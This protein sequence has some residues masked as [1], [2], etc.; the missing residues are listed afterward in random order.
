MLSRLIT[1]VIFFLT[2]YRFSLFGS[3]YSNK[4]PQTMFV[5]KPFFLKKVVCT[6]A[7]VLPKLVQN[8]AVRA[9]AL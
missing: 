4:H 2:S 6:L 3:S 8:A 7:V 5:L 1:T 9:R